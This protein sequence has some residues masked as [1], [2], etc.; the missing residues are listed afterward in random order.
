MKD[1]RHEAARWLKQAENDLQF[2]RIAIREEYF[3]QACFIAQQAAEK[4]L[5]SSLYGLG[6]RIVLGHSVVDLLSRLAVHQPPSSSLQE[7]AGVLDQYYV[8]TR[9]PNGLPGGV[10]FEAFGRDQAEAALRKAEAFLTLARQ[11]AAEEDGR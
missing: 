5:K 4:S 2:G 10:P 9:Y 6:E 7:A 11:H 3:H 8:P 1:S